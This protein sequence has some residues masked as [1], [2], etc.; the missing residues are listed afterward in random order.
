MEVY[1]ILTEK[2]VQQNQSCLFLDELNQRKIVNK[3]SFC[4]IHAFVDSIT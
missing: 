4:Y 2:L 1:N 3:L